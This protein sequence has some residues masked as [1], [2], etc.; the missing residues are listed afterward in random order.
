MKKKPPEHVNLERW[1]VSYAD[2]I[3]LLFAFF[4]IMYAMSQADKS[5]MKKVLASM[6]VAFEGA[7]PGVMSLTGTSG[8][9]TVNIFDNTD[10]VRGR[11]IDLPAGKA[12]TASDPDSELQEV[13]ELLEETMSL[14]LGA[15]DV[16]APLRME[17]D[18]RGLII[19][20]AV[21]DFFA[22]NS[23]EVRPD[24]RPI[25][26]RMGSV[27]SRTKRL[28]RLEGHTDP[29][30]EHVKGYASDWELSS[31]R[32]AW[33]ARYW[34][35]RFPFEPAHIGVAGY[36]HFRPITQAKLKW[37]RAKN[38]RVEVIILNNQFS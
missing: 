35:A 23:S 7:P 20:I 1:L 36:S 37:N 11:L 21:K 34:I 28:I 16:E 29:T 3:T 22:E 5:K 32:A 30:E 19:R 2:F 18:S 24:L 6:K 38:R 31:A 8:G 12:N 25:L 9:H 4:V 15:T 10:L 27:L 17:F 33:I 14:D 26:D 13:K